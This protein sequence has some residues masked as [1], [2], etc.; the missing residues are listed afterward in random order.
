MDA[1]IVTLNKEKYKIPHSDGARR[2]SL[3][4]LFFGD[5]PRIRKLTRNAGVNTLKRPFVRLLPKQW[6]VVSYLHRNQPAHSRPAI[7]S[8]TKLFISVPCLMCCVCSHA[9]MA[10]SASLF[11][12]LPSPLSFM[13]LQWLLSSYA[14]F[15]L[16]SS[17][18]CVYRCSSLSSL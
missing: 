11:L 16:S 17:C 18:L 12:V 8:S 14:G 6:L 2:K 15:L 9:R 4:S 13:N 7:T 1:T 10:S 5:A 3:A